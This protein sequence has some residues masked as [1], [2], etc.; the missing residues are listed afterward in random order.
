MSVPV[1]SKLSFLWNFSYYA[2]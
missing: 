1:S 2:L